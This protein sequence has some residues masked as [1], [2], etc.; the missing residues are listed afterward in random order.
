M[1]TL[2]AVVKP[3]IVAEIFVC[4]LWRVGKYVY[5]ISA[6]FRSASPDRVY[7]LSNFILNFLRILFVM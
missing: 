4:T 3:F 2:E 1:E 7:W 5:L 6:L